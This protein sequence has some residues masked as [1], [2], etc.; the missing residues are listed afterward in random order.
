MEKE[1]PTEAE[2]TPEPMDTDATADTNN[3][4][5]D[6][7]VSFL[8]DGGILKT[9][10]TFSP[11]GTK[12]PP[13][14]GSKVTSHYTGT[15]KSDGSKFDSSVDRGDPFKFTIGQ[16]QVIKGWDQGFASMK[17]GEKG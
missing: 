6:I 3:I 1:P 9:I 11:V 14:T 15:L 4:T 7:D 17:V 5:E 13:P 8:K 10:T 2:P 16:G 12:G